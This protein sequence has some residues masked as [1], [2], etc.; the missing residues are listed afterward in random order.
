MNNQLIPKTILSTIFALAALG[1]S[2]SAEAGEP[3]EKCP[4]VCG[5]GVKQW[6]EHCDDGNKYNTDGCLNT[7]KKASCGD[8]FVWEGYEDCDGGDNCTEYCKFEEPCCGDGKVQKGESCD[9]G[10]KYNTDSCLN[11]CEHACCGDGFVWEGYEDCDGG[12][13][14]T[15]SCEFEKPYCGDGKVNQ[16]WEHCDDGNG[17]NTDG[18]LDTCK[19]AKCGDG[20]VWEGKEDCDGKEWW[21]TDTCKNKCKYD[22]DY[23]GVKNCEDMC[24][25]T[26]NPEKKVPTSGSLNPNHHSLRDKDEYFEVFD[27]KKKKEVDSEYKLKDTG[28]C[29]CEQILDELGLGEGQ[30][31]FGCSPGTMKNWVKNVEKGQAGP[32]G[33]DL[34][35]G[36]QI[37]EPLPESEELDLEEVD[38]EEVDSEQVDSEELDLEAIDL[39]GTPEMGCN[40]GG[41]R[42]HAPAWAFF[43]LALAAFGLRRRS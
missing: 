3:C 34:E 8:D 14:C 17:K 15:E 25:G 4:P 38:L 29:S 7:C 16:K 13:Y 37:P 33:G 2:S 24:P 36:D 41:L 5:D 10:N 39:T 20:F 9:D 31:K 32:V 6:P 11:T 43:G 26:K 1:I 42:G 35:L 22:D 21:C 19:E 27:P 28:G 23:D 12:E 40:M 18:C 30:Y